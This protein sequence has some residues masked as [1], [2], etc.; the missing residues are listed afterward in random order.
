M[1]GVIAAGHP[2]T[3]EAGAE[4]LKLGGNAVDAAV[5][6]TFASFVTESALVNIGGGGIA[7]LYDPV[8]QQAVVYDFFSTMPGLGS[9]TRPEHLDFRQVMVDFGSAQQPFYIGRGSVAVPGV[10]AG[11]CALVE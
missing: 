5:A 4:I 3:A 8:Q 7:Q 6:A 2:Q 10:V 1:S 9:L 11:L